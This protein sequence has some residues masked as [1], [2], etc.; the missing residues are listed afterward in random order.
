M[1]KNL[2]KLSRGGNLGLNKLKD[3][4]KPSNN[5]ERTMGFQVYKH[6][7]SLLGKDPGYSP[8]TGNEAAAYIAYAVSENSFIFPITP[9][10]PMGEYMDLW[11][12]YGKKNIWN[13]VVSVNMM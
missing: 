12:T 4:I 9:S 1:F 11:K 2:N 10:S 13:K 3:V 7:S 6:F 8:M 5:L